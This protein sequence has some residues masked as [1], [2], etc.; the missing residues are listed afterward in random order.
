MRLILL[1]IFLLSTFTSYSQASKSRGLP[2]TTI[3]IKVYLNGVEQQGH[4]SKSE[5]AKYDLVIRLS[6]PYYKVQGFTAAYDCPSRALFDVAT[7]DYSGHIIKAGDKFL[8]ASLI[9]DTLE[10]IGLILEYKGKKYT[11]DGRFFRMVD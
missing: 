3:K 10:I 5:F 4:I 8:M 7:K 1:T 9:G 6:D 2:K 11:C